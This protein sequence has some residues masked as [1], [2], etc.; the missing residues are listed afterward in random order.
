MTLV[1]SK[2][3]GGSYYHYIFAASNKDSALA[4]SNK[5]ETVLSVINIDVGGYVE[6]E[7][8]AIFAIIDVILLL[9]D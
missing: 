1:C 2:L 3:L 6:D 5:D 9:F 7:E 4:W 8:L